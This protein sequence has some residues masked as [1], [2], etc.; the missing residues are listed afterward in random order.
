MGASKVILVDL[1]EER[2]EVAK[3]IGIADVYV[4]GAKEDAVARVLEE[5]EGLGA[6]VIYTAC[7]APQAQVDA[8]NMA[9]NRARVSFFGGLPAGKNN[10]TLDTNI[11]H[12][13]E[14]FI[15]GAH[16]AMPIHHQQAVDLIATGKIDVKKFLTHTFPLDE[17]DKA[18][19]A[20]ENKDGLRVVV[21][22]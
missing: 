20:A 19:A 21:N 15:T 10:V 16:G 3:K 8:L 22:P 13:K 17:I 12:Y 2:L 1:L 6:D 9:K 14:L 7:P 11:I 5:T 18:F 4:C